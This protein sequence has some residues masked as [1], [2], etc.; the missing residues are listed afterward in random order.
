LQDTREDIKITRKDR[1]LSINRSPLLL[2]LDRTKRGGQGAAALDRRRRRCSGEL[3]ARLR[4]K[5]ERGARLEQDGVLTSGGERRGR[6]ESEA[7]PAAWFCAAALADREQGRRMGGAQ[8]DGL[9]Q[10]RTVLGSASPFIGARMP[11]QRPGGQRPVSWPGT[12][13]PRR[14]A[15]MGSARAWLPGRGGP[16]LQLGRW[17]G[18]GGLRPA[19]QMRPSAK[20]TVQ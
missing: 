4:H 8:G 9:G 13:W 16:G 10:G 2:P 12:P 18:L 5:I 7:M 15:Q 14:R 19:E 6:P 3:K 20:M 11:R 1:G 17:V